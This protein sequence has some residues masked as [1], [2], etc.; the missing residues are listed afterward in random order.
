MKNWYGISGEKRRG[1]IIGQIQLR[2]EKLKRN[3]L[4]GRRGKK[5]R[6]DTKQEK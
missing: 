6:K 3:Q 1:E 5:K 4:K 2:G